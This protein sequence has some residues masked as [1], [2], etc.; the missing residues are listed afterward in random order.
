M[1][2]LMKIKTLKLFSFIYVLLTLPQHVHGEIQSTIPI[3]Q[4]QYETLSRDT[5]SDARFALI[6][7]GDTL[8][9]P[10]QIR[11]RGASSAY[12]QK[13]IICHKASG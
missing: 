3:I 12:Y 8:N 9:L 2:Q 10:A 13:K 6:E 5:F 1:R 11:H 7:D 4:L